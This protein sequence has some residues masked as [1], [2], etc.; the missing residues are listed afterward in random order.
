MRCP[1]KCVKFKLK[2]KLFPVNNSAIFACN[3][4]PDFFTMKAFFQQFG[5]LT[6]AELN[7]V[8][9]FLTKRLLKKGEFLIQEGKICDE[10]VFVK[11]G[12]LRSF[13]YS[14][15]AEEITYCLTFPDNVMTAFSSLITG[16]PTE[17]SIQALTDVEV[18]VINKQS[19]E[20]L[21]Q[22]GNG[23][24]KL[25]KH[26]TELQYIGLENRIFGY[27]KYSA[28][29]RYEEL[30]NN[31]AEFIQKIPV[32]YLASYLN[33]TPRHLSRLRKEIIQKAF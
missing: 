15:K 22:S 10:V 29:K 25:G 19:L 28:K 2:T 18:I 6:A 26:L 4:L 24:L 23:W 3:F 8:D 9:H 17:E 1:V 20:K 13:Y 11:S 31:Q 14:D 32:Q 12:I 27:Q 7:Q 33:I 21:Y 5:L 30:L 16:N